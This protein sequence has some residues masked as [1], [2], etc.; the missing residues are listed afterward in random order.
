MIPMIRR[1]KAVA[2]TGVVLGAYVAAYCVAFNFR[3]PAANLAYWCYVSEG[4]PEWSEKAMYAVFY[5]AYAVHRTVF[6]G[7]LNNADRDTTVSKEL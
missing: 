6:H 7:Q 5:P 4:Y 2:I 1:R 3:T